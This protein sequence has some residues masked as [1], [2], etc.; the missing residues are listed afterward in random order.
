[1]TT[2]H[3]SGLAYGRCYINYLLNEWK[4]EISNRNTEGW[5]QRY[6]IIHTQKR[7]NAVSLEGHSE[8]QWSK[9]LSWGWWR[10]GTHTGTKQREQAWFIGHE[11]WKSHGVLRSNLSVSFCRC[12]AVELKLQGFWGQSNRGSNLGPV[13]TSTATLGKSV[14]LRVAS[15]VKW[16]ILA[17]AHQPPERGWIKSAG[18]PVGQNEWEGQVVRRQERQQGQLQGWVGLQ[19]CGSPS[20]WHLLMHPKGHTEPSRKDLTWQIAPGVCLGF[21]G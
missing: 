7:I 4:D 11:I 5:L 3:S 1:M 20:W 18:G 12:W 16:A 13:L 19:A 14:H 21:Q 9:T 6:Y 10:E 2:N 8:V 17:K 15:C